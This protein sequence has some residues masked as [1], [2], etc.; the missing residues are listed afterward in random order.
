MMDNSELVSELLQS[1]LDEVK[2]LQTRV[3][4]LPTQ[5]QPDYR[6]RLEE[7]TKAIQVLPSQLKAGSSSLDLTPITSRLDRLE[8][9]GR[10]SPERKA[11]QYV[12]IG[13]YSFGLM[14]ILLAGATWLA[15]SWRSERDEY[16]QAF[17]RDN[18]R[19]RYTKQA[20]PDY[21]NF[22][23]AK[24]KDTAIYTWVSE[25]E[26]ADE[27]RELARQASEQ[28]KALSNQANQLEGKP[29]TK[30]KKRG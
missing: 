30:G 5:E 12:Q 4:K 29:M 28:A 19:V 17:S 16:E 18:W 24:F 9:Q 13:A 14:V 25:Q 15:L 1:V 8:Q 6:T 26:Q 27:K 11:S 21:Y 20:N 23:E 10:Q 7:L 2:T 3:S 22:M